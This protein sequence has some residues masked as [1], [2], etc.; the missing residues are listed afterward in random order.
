MH[1]CAKKFYV[2]TLL[3]ELGFDTSTCTGD[4]TYSPLRSDSNTY[5]GQICEALENKFNLK[6][7]QTNMCLPRLFWNPKLHKNPYKAR[8]I[9]GA[10]QPNHLTS[11]LIVVLNSSEN[12]L[13]SIVWLYTI[14]V[15]L[16]CFGVSTLRHS[17]LRLSEP[18]MCTMSKFMISQLSI[19]N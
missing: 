13:K 17:T 18:V 12:T 3:K 11:M 8:F 4:Q 7:D 15:A 5:I 6:I 10:V 9:A 14:T 1:S 16:T 2:L 19:P